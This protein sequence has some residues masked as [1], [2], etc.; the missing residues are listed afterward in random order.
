MTTIPSETRSL[1]HMAA[2]VEELYAQS[3]ESVHVRTDRMFA[4]LMVIQ[5]LAGIIAAVWI[6][7]LTWSG[8]VSQVHL[9]VWAAVVLGGAIS[10]FPVLMAWK[11]PGAVITRH[12]IAVAQTLTSALLIHLT[13]G[14]IETHFHV[15]GS[16][17]F[18]AFYRDWRVLLTATVIVAGDHLMRGL[19]WPQSVFGVLSPSTW[20]WLE[21]AGWVLFEDTFLILS[22]RHSLKDMMDVATRRAELEDQNT[23][24][25]REVRERTAELTMAHKDLLEASRHA[26]M[27]EVATNV[28][29]NVGN[30]LNSVNVSA[31]TVA[32][33]VRNLR[34]NR[35]ESVAEL[36]RANAADLPGFLSR[37]PRGRELPDYLLKLTESLAQPQAAI[38]EEL[39]LLRKNIE[40]VKEVVAMQQNYARVA[41]V[42]EKVPPVELVEDAI[43]MNSI[44]LTRHEVKLVREYE[45]V[46]AI[47][48]DRH[49]V[50]QI[51]VNLLSNAK[52]ALKEENGDK[53][54]VVRI[55]GDGADGVTIAVADNGMGIPEENLTRVFQHGF[56]T[57]KDG[58]GFGL[59]SGA[60]T[61]K[62]LGG[63][64]TVQSKGAGLGAVFTLELPAHFNHSHS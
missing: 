23:L 52:Q 37:D 32:A 7:P 39:Q 18:L 40:H 20:R 2:R 61:A 63:R 25:E 36:L 16:L 27:A 5:W 47:M 35:L 56:T 11:R 45:D 64:L 19:F 30:V 14:R 38:I 43:R 41:C 59:H 21:H 15:F 55:A 44:A 34:I 17:A 8:A 31:D 10:F 33:K 51:L 49:Q 26:G 62:A 4:V 24:I 50:L 3:Q 58:H 13:G 48:T 28:L 22:I 1:T 57:R 54:V 53:R 9:H 42:L 6:S 12:V 46:P 60:L 29:H